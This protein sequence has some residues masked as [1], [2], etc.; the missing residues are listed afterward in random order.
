MNGESARFGFGRNWKH[1]AERHFSEERVEISKSAMLAFLGLQD[2]QGKYFLDVG[3][4]SGLHSL[5][6]LRAGAARIVGFDY[7]PDSVSTTQ[8]LRQ[9]AGN[10]EHWEVTQGSILDLQFVQGLD[11]ADVVYA[12][13]VLHHTGDMWKAIE[14]TSFL[15]KNGG[16]LYLALYTSGIM[17]PSDDYWLEVKQRY[18]RSDWL[19][20]R[21][22]EAGYVWKFMLGSNILKLPRV[23]ARGMAYKKSRGMDMYTDIVDWLGGWPMEFASVEQVKSFC[24]EKLNMTLMNI[25]TGEANTSYLFKKR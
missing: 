23:V 21:M 9:I 16:T 22:M 20:K 7:D 17:A 8:M 24:S 11:P 2:L 19:A 15:V 3:C 12:W 13:G 6:A 25:E 5:A 18:N 10:P 1:Y 14:N 4:G